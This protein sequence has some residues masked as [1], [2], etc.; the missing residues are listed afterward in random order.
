[1]SKSYD[2]T[3]P[4]FLPPNKLRKVVM[5]IKSDSSGPGEPKDPD[6]SLIFQIH[7][8]MLPADRVEALAADYRGGLS[9]GEA[10]QRLADDLEAALAG[11]RARYEELMTRP[12]TMEDLL[13]HGA[14]RA[15][16]IAGPLLDRVRSAFG[17]GPRKVR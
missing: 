7:R 5:K 14:A 1:M 15:N 13:L 9:W 4:C 3:I 10:K 12:D 6:T 2:N 16:A 8:A 11:P 17:A